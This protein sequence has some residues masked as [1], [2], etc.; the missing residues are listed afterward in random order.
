MSNEGMMIRVSTPAPSV[1]FIDLVPEAVGGKFLEELNGDGAGSFRLP[2]SSQRLSDSPEIVNSRN[3]VQHSVNGTIRGAWL[4]RNC[5]KILVGKGEDAALFYEFSGPG[6]RDWFHDAVVYPTTDQS[7]SKTK[8]GSRYFNFSSKAGSWYHA[9]DWTAPTSLFFQQ[10]LNPD[11]PWRY[12]PI[13][14]PDAPQAKWI[15]DRDS[16]AGAPI[17]DVYFRKTFTS[18][19]P[20]SFALFA[21]ADDEIQAFIDGTPIIAA[22]DPRGWTNLYRG[23]IDLPAGDH[24][25]AIRATNHQSQGAMVAALY[26]YKDPKLALPAELITVTG[27]A[28]WLCN[29]YPE[30]APGM[31][32][33][34]VLRI[35]MEE[36]KA[37]GVSSFQNIDLSFTDIADSHGDPWDTTL[38]WAFDVGMEY[39]EVIQR[40]EEL[41]V[42]VY[43]H[44]ETFDLRAYN[45]RGFDRSEQV[46]EDQPV[47]FRRGHNVISA[48]EDTEAVLKNVYLL[49]YGDKSLSEVVDP[50]STIPTYGRIEGFVQTDSSM[51]KAKARVIATKLLET[52]K[53]PLESATIV[54]TDVEDH[55]PWVNFYVGD[56]VRG[57]GTTGS[58]RRRVVSIAASADATTGQPT[59]EVELDT[60]SQDKVARINR[61][62]SRMPK[63]QSLGSTVGAG[64]SGGG[65]GGSGSSGSDGSSGAYTGG[66]YTGG[67]VGSGYGGSAGGGAQVFVQPNEPTSARIGTLWYDTDAVY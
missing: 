21:T 62:L 39:I 45:R 34:E 10:S 55:T 12:A 26:S 11:N 20:L 31:S 15:W 50:Y 41:A 66:G 64:G 65:G 58:R 54:I 2:V 48:T 46:G 13:G 63:F 17:G 19:E 29:G 9:E 43:I 57:P 16:T 8:L 14:F 51:G 59:Y 47:T 42:E 60:L 44:P 32:P 56:W 6:L 33:G 24:V 49:N 18:T 1:D 38:D 23:D 3:V 22:N 37:R 36:A 4:M 28:G 35:L 67:D 5:H 53:A 52:S 27:D 7:L 40:M 30:T 61:F 25:V